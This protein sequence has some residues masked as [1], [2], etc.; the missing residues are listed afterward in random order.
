MKKRILVFVALFASLFA[1]A[2]CGSKPTKK[3]YTVAFDSQGGTAVKFQSVEEGS[4]AKKPAAPLYVQDERIK[5]FLG[6]Y[7]EAGNLYDFSTP[8]NGNITLTAKWSSEYGVLAGG[9]EGKLYNFKYADAAYRE[10]LCATL[11]RWLIDK[12]ISIPLYYSNGLVMYNERITTA[13]SEYV[14]G[15]GYGATYGSFTGEDNYRTATTAM[16]DTANKFDYRSDSDSSVIGMIEASLYTLD[17]N[18]GFTGFEALPELA[19]GFPVPVSQNE[20]G[21]WVEAEGATSEAPAYEALSRS[22][23]VYVRTDMKWADGE[24]IT[25]KHFEDNLKILLDPTLKYYRANSCYS[26]AFVIKNAK[27]YYDGECE[28][29]KVG[30]EFDYENNCIIYT[31]TQ[32]LSQIDFMYNTGSYLFG[33]ADKEFHDKLGKDGFGAIPQGTTEFT[34]VRASGEF[35]VSYYEDEKQVRYTKNPNYVVNPLRYHTTVFSQFT[36]TKVES[37]EAAWEL[38][39]NG[40]LDAA[41]VPSAEYANYVNDPRAKTSPGATVWR[42]SINQASD[43]YLKEFTG[44]AWSGNALMQNRNFQWALYFGVNREHLA[45]NIIVAADPC[46]FYVNNT[47][48]VAVQAV[49]G[50][51]DSEAAKLVAGTELTAT[52][53]DLLE[54]SYGYSE[55]DALEFYVAALDE[56]VADGKVDPNKATTLSIEINNWPATSPVQVNVSNYIEQEYERIFN[57]QTKYP[58]IKFNVETSMTDSSTSYYGK[59]MVAQYDMAMAGI[60]GGSLDILGLFDVWSSSDLNGLRLSFGVNTEAIVKYEDLIE[61]DG[62]FWTY[63]ALVAA[64]SAPTWVVAGV[65]TADYQAA[66]DEVSGNMTSINNHVMAALAEDAEKLAA[67]E[68]T[69][70]RFDIALSEV[71]SPAE[72]FVVLE[73]FIAAAEAALGAEL[74]DEE[75]EVIYAYEG[76]KAWIATYAAED[77]VAYLYANGYGDSFGVQ[78]EGLLADAAEA[79]AAYEAEA[80]DET[81]AA[82][83]AACEALAEWYYSV[84]A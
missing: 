72:A 46:Q 23:K 49:A 67:W 26:G 13:V 9:T 28:W 52:G 68:E 42:L 12:G 50:Y 1:L 78:V 6:W 75:L 70:N 81:K 39:N 32:E 74:T 51:R 8:V 15:M 17:W 21:E 35:V 37:A 43:E 80:N 48:K 58:N 77:I 22:W 30:F 59:Q 40:E 76:A 3:Q 53:I 73:D 82:V 66:V 65:K 57:S 41:S 29:E 71:I 11:E 33:V 84:W 79:I 61:W 16:A 38:F 63:D 20:K 25:L 60:S 56:L 45:K 27:K 2:S 54:G 44:G 34:S 14:A 18:E 47:Y 10:L 36:E 24:A 19:S 55:A 31:L 62:E 4:T 83:K 64:A 69:F 7:D 5:E